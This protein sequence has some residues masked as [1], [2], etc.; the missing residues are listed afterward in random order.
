ML[1]TPAT[2]TD[3]SAEKYRTQRDML[4][5]P[6]LWNDAARVT[7]HSFGPETQWPMRSCTAKVNPRHKRSAVHFASQASRSM[8]Y[9]SWSEFGQSPVPLVDKPLVQNPMPILVNSTPSALKGALDGVIERGKMTRSAAAATLATTKPKRACR[10][11]PAIGISMMLA[12]LRAGDTVLY[13]IVW[14]PYS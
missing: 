14:K 9:A 7:P 8:Q 11:I 12:A 10:V 5:S 6:G 2:T 13:Q 1:V 4:L 3:K